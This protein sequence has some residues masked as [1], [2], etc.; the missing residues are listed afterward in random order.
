MARAIPQ[1]GSAGERD[2][3]AV[4]CSKGNAEVYWVLVLGRTS[5]CHACQ[6]MSPPTAGQVRALHTSKPSSEKKVHFD[7]IDR[8][9][10]E[11][12]I[13]KELMQEVRMN[14][15]ALVTRSAPLLRLQCSKAQLEQC[16]E[17]EMDLGRLWKNAKANSHVQRCRL[18]GF[19]CASTSTR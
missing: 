11:L 7:K 17:Q 5:A 15:P 2:K 19:E 3:V 6:L 18:E 14:E 12:G 4:M 1:Q 16:R 8:L 9:F 13:G 10:V